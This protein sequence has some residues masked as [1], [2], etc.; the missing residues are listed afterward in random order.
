MKYRFCTLVV[1]FLVS[2]QLFSQDLRTRLGRTIYNPDSATIILELEKNKLFNAE[3]S[4]LY[5]YFLAEQFNVSRE[6][7]Q[8]AEYF[9]KSAEL[10]DPSSKNQDLISLSYIRLN[11]LESV[12]GRFERALMYSQKG[13]QN[14]TA[15]LD[16][17]Y[18]GYAL[19]DI[20]V[21]YHDMEEFERGVEYGKKAY[22]LLT[23][24]S[25]A[26]APFIAFA[27]NAIGINFDDWEKPDSALFY[28]YKVLDNI[29]NLDST[30]ISFTFN[31]IAN[32]LLKQ[33]KYSEAEPWLNAAVRVN[34][35][36][37]DDYSLAANYTNLATIA[38]KRGDFGKAQV[39]MDSAYKYVEQ[40]ESTEKK[41][42]YLYEQYGFNKA[43]GNLNEAMDYLEQYVAVKDSIFKEERVKTLGE[44]E[45]KYQV[46]TKE[47]ELAESR[48][49]LAE[50]ELVVEA[51][52]NQLLLLLILVLISFGVGFFIYYR[53]KNK[54]RHLEQEAKLQ[55]IYAE[56]ETQKR[57]H[58][59]R[60][61][62][63]SDLHDNIGAQLTFIISSL[64]N[65]KFGNLD[66]E[67][68][69]AKIDQISGFTVETINELRDTIWAMNKDHISV[70]DLESRLAH[71]ISKAKASYPEIEFELKI[72]EGVERKLLLNSIEGMN[73]YRVI[74]EAVNNA[75]K[76]A[77]AKKISIIFSQIQ[78]K[79]RLC[80]EDD[81]VGI[82]Q[83][84]KFGNGLGNMKARAERIGRE[85]SIASEERKGT[86][87]CIY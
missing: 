69:S 84:N 46:E 40:S 45:A 51:Q 64:N 29:E 62:I 66:L 63:S 1:F 41:R 47:R 78:D 59:Q 53:Q 81:G 6:N 72:E 22:Q 58:E 71:L 68:M 30:R 70:E 85:L 39:M 38:Y 28:H 33:K 43:K 10:I 36:S 82:I 7:D 15:A 83:K 4:G 60:D 55:T 65:L 86:Q 19:L 5:Y 37:M 76:H 73:Y 17:N 49:A 74:Q 13:L 57:L 27:L 2:A 54:N 32:T 8:A 20:S 35:K 34:Q 48:A 23:S 77:N 61:R 11:R 79:I 3:D 18:M 21:V 24:Y 16:S 52:N 25:K 42:D 80:V 67:K 9:L 56:Q 50:N 12:A 44:L 14:A 75:L 31:N 26:R 87:I